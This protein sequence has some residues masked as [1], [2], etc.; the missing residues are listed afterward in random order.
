MRVSD[1]LPLLLAV[2]GTQVAAQSFVSSSAAATSTSTPGGP[3]TGKLGDALVVGNNPVGV[4]Y[5]ATFPESAFWKYAYPDGGNIEGD[6]TATAGED[7]EGVVFD[8][9]L[10]NLP[11][12][13]G[14]ITYHL[15]VAPVP[16]DGNCSATLAHLDPFVRGEA[17][18]CNKDAPATCQVGDLSGKHGAIPADATEHAVRYTDAYASTRD[19]IGAFFGNR[20]IVFHYPNKTRITCAN[21][22]VA[23]EEGGGNGGGGSGS[24][25]ASATLP[26][27]HS[28][29][30]ATT[31]VLA[32]TSGGPSASGPAG[33]TASVPAP[34]SSAA[35]LRAGI[36]GAVLFGAAVVFML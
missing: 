20:S 3:E 36:A 23:E 16:A 24:A 10:T 15:H 26:P 27:P 18:P 17:S 22:A 13:G 5:K 9:K 11:Q 19:G 31:R 2:V 7:G 35:G 8:L 29:A 12:I 14:P 33:P 34:G 1:N 21:F 4:V 28:N 32:P 30:T 25:S 6:I